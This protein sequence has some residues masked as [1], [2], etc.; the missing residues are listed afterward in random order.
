MYCKKEIKVLIK[1]CSWAILS[2]IGGGF[3]AS[4]INLV[5]EKGISDI[6]HNHP[7]S[8]TLYLFYI[9]ILILIYAI[10][11]PSEKLF[12]RYKNNFDLKE[13]PFTFVEGV[14]VIL[15]TSIIASFAFH[16]KLFL[17]TL[18]FSPLF[19]FLGVLLCKAPEVKEGQSDKGCTQQNNKD[20]ASALLPDEPI[21]CPNDDNFGRD[22]F[23]EDIYN[24]IIKYPFDNSYVFGLFG[25]WGEGKTSVLNLLRIKLLSREDRKNEV[26]NQADKNKKH[27]PDV[28]KLIVLDFDPWGFS[29]QVNLINAFYENL[30]KALNQK[31]ILNGIKSTLNKYL[32]IISPAFKL[33][34]FGLSLNLNNQSPE[35]MKN[36]IERCLKNIGKKIVIIIDDIDRLDKERILQVFEIV[37]RSANLKNTIFVM[38]FD[39]AQVSRLIDDEHQVG[40]SSIDKIVQNPINLPAIEQATLEDFIFKELNSLFYKIQINQTDIDNFNNAAFGNFKQFYRLYGA[41]LFSTLR[42]AIRY[43]N[44]ITI[45]L[46]AI[47]DEVNVQDFLL[48]ELIRIFYPGVYN[49]IWEN[50]SLFSI[51]S[52]EEN[53]SLNYLYN[54][55]FNYRKQLHDSIKAHLSKIKNNKDN[56]EVIEYLLKLLFPL[57]ENALSNGTN[58]LDPN[59]DHYRPAKRIFIPEIF[60]KYFI[61][62][63]PSNEIP[64]KT[65]EDLL[66]KWNQQNTNTEDVKND[67][68]A[69]K[70]E[71][72]PQVHKLFKKLLDFIYKISN[73]AANKVITT[74]YSNINSFV[75]EAQWETTIR[76]ISD[77]IIHIINYRIPSNEIENL[78]LDLIKNTPSIHLAT[79]IM[80]FCRTNDTQGNLNNIYTN[81]NETKLNVTFADRLNE[82]FRIKKKDIFKEDK[83]DYYLPT[84]LTIWGSIDGSTKQ[85]MNDYIFSL[86]KNNPSYLIKIVSIVNDNWAKEL[87]K[88]INEVELYEKCK[89]FSN[90]QIFNTVEKSTIERYIKDYEREQARVKEGVQQKLFSNRN[91]QSISQADFH[92]SKSEYKQALDKYEEALQLADQVNTIQSDDKD[93]IEYKIWQCLLE[94]SLNNYKPVQDYFDKAYNRAGNDNAISALSKKYTGQHVVE[95]YFC[96]FYFLKWHFS[97]PEEKKNA[98]SSFLLHYLLI[99]TFQL[100]PEDEIGQRAKKLKAEMDKH[101]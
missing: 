7:W 29:P 10:Y 1:N 68:L 44:A 75:D 14:S 11:K 15:I 84:V 72:K 18:I 60:P 83:Q 54:S 2:M 12:A 43:I 80:S 65:I 89:K 66:I 53:I 17:I 27:I 39:V 50:R 30:Y 97:K 31:Y 93:Q 82:E 77:I 81:T 21:R 94:L 57:V 34:G 19:V 55:E 61:L 70:D 100:L 16:I 25:T 58:T 92:F 24:Q 33:H 47:K 4:L 74:L 52:I 32:N 71:K 13:P 59:F 91:S 69:Y 45:T 101:N 88:L 48:L 26:N 98:K 86:I 41:K 99:E 38:S 46:P 90:D 67:I 56:F 76:G 73:D 8:I 78:L 64:D 9:F 62:K 28:G 79:S 51:P 63:V 85:Q 42:H 3:F 20:D 6:I 96:L 95:L 49:D 37:K 23:V 87:K 35:A 5:P 40:K 22:K 36:E